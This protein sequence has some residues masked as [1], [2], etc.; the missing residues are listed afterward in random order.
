[1]SDAE[2]L[3]LFRRALRDVDPERDEDWAAVALDVDI[4]SLGLDSIRNME[5]VGFLE[6]A[7][8][9]ALT[10]EDLADVRTLRDL[11]ALLPAG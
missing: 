11:G 5:L 10:D 1:M 7:T 3:E 4:E 6:D 8:G 9:A 2:M